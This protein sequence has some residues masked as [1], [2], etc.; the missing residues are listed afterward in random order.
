[1]AE[2]DSDQFTKWN[3]VPAEKVEPSELGGEL[4]VARFSFDNTGGTSASAGD[5]INLTRLPEGSRVLFGEIEVETTFATNADLD[6]GIASDV[7]KYSDG[8]DVD[9]TGVSQIAQNVAESGLATDQLGANFEDVIATFV[10]A[11]GTGKF[12]GYLVYVA[13]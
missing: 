1:M 8:L 10:T 11:G 2:F 5:T 3:N 6:I 4:R 9:A 12:Q 13:Y 7:D